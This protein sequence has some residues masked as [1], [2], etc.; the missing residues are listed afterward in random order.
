MISCI[1][2]TVPS[3][4][5]ATDGHKTKV[6]DPSSQCANLTLRY[7]HHLQHKLPLGFCSAVS[8]LLKPLFSLSYLL[9]LQKG[10]WMPPI[11]RGVQLNSST[12]SCKDRTQVQSRL[13]WL[14]GIH[15][16]CG[17]HLG[18]DH[19]CGAYENRRCWCQ[20]RRTEIHGAGSW[21]GAIGNW[22]KRTDDCRGTDERAGSQ[23]C[24]WHYDTGDTHRR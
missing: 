23:S 13:S 11:H 1:L 6:E 3:P 2:N 10:H 22:W 15:Q 21:K 9:Q 24:C 5:T 19:C 16:R 12:G 7:W 20:A 8:S 17:W 4:A 18:S 14:L